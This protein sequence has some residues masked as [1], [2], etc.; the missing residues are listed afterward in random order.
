MF[1]DASAIVAIIAM[2]KDAPTLIAKLKVAREAFISPISQYESIL[3][4]ARALNATIEAS[5][6]LVD[7]F[8]REKSLQ[9]LAIDTA[10][11]TDAVAAFARYGKGRHRAKLTMGDCFAYACAKTLDVPLLCKGNDFKH[12]DIKLA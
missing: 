4:L 3:G 8:I 2:E 6:E 7:D 9:S 1:V 11:A 12:T 10:I 5:A